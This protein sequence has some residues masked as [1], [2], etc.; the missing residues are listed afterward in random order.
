MK[1]YYTMI[2]LIINLIGIKAQTVCLKDL[3]MKDSVLYFNNKVYNGYYDCYD[4]NGKLRGHGFINNGQLDSITDYFDKKGELTEKVWYNTNR[5]IKRRIYRKAFFTKLIIDLKD[6]VE[7]G[8]WERYYSNG[9]INEQR[10]YELGKAV[11]L[12]TTWD[13]KG[14][15]LT[16]INFS[17]NPIIQKEYSSTEINIIYF[18]KESGK[19]LKKEKVKK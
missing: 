1:I 2:F 3:V 7:D 6:N 12:W 10:H 9:K 4:D 18:D 19:I 17:V 16:E 11:G 15:I 5:E 14:N 8:L 13:R